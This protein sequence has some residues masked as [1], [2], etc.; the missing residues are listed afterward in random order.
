MEFKGKPL[1]LFAKILSTIFVILG[2]TLMAFF[3]KEK[4]E[5]KHVVCLILAAGFIVLIFLPV[6]ISIW[7]D[8]A[9]EIAELKYKKFEK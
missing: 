1:S 6:D 2:L 7:L 4:L 9:V 8:K 3:F 5:I